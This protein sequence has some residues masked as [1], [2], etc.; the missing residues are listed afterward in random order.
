LLRKATALDGVIEKPL[1]NANRFNSIAIRYQNA[2]AMLAHAAMMN[3]S[4]TDDTARLDW[5]DSVHGL[6]CT[7]PAGKCHVLAGPFGR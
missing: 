7:T 1:A 5:L 3:L 4:D 2:R 6:Q